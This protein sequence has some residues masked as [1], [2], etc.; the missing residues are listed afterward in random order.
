[1]PSTKNKPDNAAL[2]NGVIIIIVVLAVGLAVYSGV[3]ALAPEQ[4]VVSGRLGGMPGGK[5][6]LMREQNEAKDGG[7]PGAGK[8]DAGAQT[9]SNQ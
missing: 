2:K 6:G 3:R 8:E 5:A 7:N 4:P 1:M 9:G